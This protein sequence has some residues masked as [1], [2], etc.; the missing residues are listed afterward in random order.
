MGTIMDNRDKLNKFTSN[1]VPQLAVTAT[2]FAGHMVLRLVHDHLLRLDLT[3]Y[4]NVIRQQVAKIN[5]KLKAL[6][7][8]RLCFFQTSA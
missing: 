7:L 4:D 8:V 5:G 2:Q 3:H 6:K 1:Q